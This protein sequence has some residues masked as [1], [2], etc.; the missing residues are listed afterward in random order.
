MVR[1]DTVRYGSGT[2]IFTC[3]YSIY[4]YIVAKL[5][6]LDEF[7]TQKEDLLAKLVELEQKIRFLELEH[8]DKLYDIEKKMVL[9]KD[10]L[11]LD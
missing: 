3:A 8:Q 5:A 1:F 7:K 6:A 11:D 4:I 10:R 9:D 2:L